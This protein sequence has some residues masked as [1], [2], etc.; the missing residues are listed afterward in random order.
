M[1]NFL[2]VVLEFDGAVSRA[3]KLLE[4]RRICGAALET[5]AKVHRRKIK[6]YE[7]SVG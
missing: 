3:Q 6:S 2:Q 5:F 7:V 1:N 4:R